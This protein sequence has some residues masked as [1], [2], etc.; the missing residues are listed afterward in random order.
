[1]ELGIDAAWAGKTIREVLQRELGYS[2]NLIKKLKFSEGGILVNGEFRTVRYVLCEGDVLSLK[3]EDS[4]ADVSPYTIAAELPIDVVYEDDWITVVNKPADMPA[5]PSLGHRLDTVSNALA[6]RYRDKPYVFRPVNRLDRDTSGCMLTANTRDASYKMYIF[7]TTGQITKTYLALLDGV[8]AEKSGRLTSYMHR[9]GDSI[10]K[11]EETS[12][13][14]PDAKIALTDYAV[15]WEDGRHAVVMA[16]PVTGRTHQI[17]VQFAGIGCPVTG[18]DLYGAASPHIGRH[19]LHSYRTEFP[20]PA[21]N[22]P[23]T[24][25]APLYP[26]MLSLLDV[27]TGDRDAVLAAADAYCYDETSPLRKD[28]PYVEE[29]H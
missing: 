28:D 7:M 17:R 26:D 5:H 20:H 23:M 14:T 11:R 22:R 4:A 10:I 21:D 6:W 1:M 19:A 25:T 16:R 12:P 9:V 13:D 8:P 18:D 24:V 2:S 29:N 15:L 27:I 3:V